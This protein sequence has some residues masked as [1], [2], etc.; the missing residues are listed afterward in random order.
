MIFKSRYSLF[1]CWSIACNSDPYPVYRKGKDVVVETNNDELSRLSFNNLRSFCSNIV[2]ACGI[3]NI[4]NH[5]FLPSNSYIIHN[6]TTKYK[7]KLIPQT[8]NTPS[9]NVVIIVNNIN[10]LREDNRL[11]PHDGYCK[12]DNFKSTSSPSIFAVNIISVPPKI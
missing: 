3:S 12:P 8:I 1:S 10:S 7:T 4:C 6:E 5:I 11:E 9:A 2:N